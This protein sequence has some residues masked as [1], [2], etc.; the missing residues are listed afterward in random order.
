MPGEAIVSAENNGKPLSGRASAP[1]PAEELTALPRP[2]SWCGG[3][4]CPFPRTPA[5]SRPS[6]VRSCLPMKNPRHALGIDIT[7]RRRWRRWPLARRG[8]VPARRLVWGWAA[9]AGDVTAAASAGKR[10]WVRCR[11]ETECP[12]ARRRSDRY[13]TPSGTTARA[14]RTPVYVTHAIQVTRRRCV[15]LQAILLLVFILMFDVA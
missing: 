10:R 1:N 9:A 13:V 15:T 7:S 2:S 6:A 4:C 3:G 14:T 12:R 11:L 8:I 5:R